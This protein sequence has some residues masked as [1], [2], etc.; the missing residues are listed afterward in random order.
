MHSLKIL[1]LTL[2]QFGIHPLNTI[3][4]FRGL[5]IYIYQAVQF[6]LKSRILEQSLSVS[7]PYPC[8][9]DR[10][11][12]AGS[13]SNHYFHQDLW[14]AQ[15]VYR[16]N[17]VHHI[18]IGS[19]IDGFVAHLLT[20]RSVEVLDIRSMKS[21]VLGMSF[22]Q[23][24]LMQIE[25][26]P[27]A[28]CDSVSCLHALEHFGLGRY[29]DPID[30][31]GHI[32]GL[33]ALTKL[34]KPDGMLLLSVPIGKERVEFNAHRIFSVNTIIKLLTKEFELI[35]FSYIDD[36]NK[37]H[38]CVEPSVVLDCMT[39]GCGLFEARKKSVNL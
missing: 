11:Q 5:L 21:Q 37:F 23:V 35:S 8:V 34:I 29:G 32:K 30:P 38:E 15:K 20:F 12:S 14:A 36:E 27:E 3:S 26:V 22:R 25:S 28:A 33:W 19:R 1:Y 4:F 17:P 9:V 7:S 2:V 24:D 13:I 10:Y 39:Y 18:D 31:V 16:N 6:Y